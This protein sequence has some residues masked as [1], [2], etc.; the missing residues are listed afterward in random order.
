MNASFSIE[1]PV[2]LHFLDRELLTFFG[3]YKDYPSRVLRR[4]LWDILFL[5]YEPLY[6]S[7][8]LIFESDP[9]WDIITSAPI[10]FETGH[11]ELLQKGNSLKSEIGDKQEQYSPRD[12]RSKYQRYFDDSFQIVADLGPT[13]RHRVTD[14]STIL[15]KWLYN[16]LNAEG[17]ARSAARLRLTA[18]SAELFDCAPRVLDAIGERGPLAITRYL[19]RRPYEEHQISP[20][21]RSAFDI[22]ITE[23]YVISQLKERDGTLATGLSNGFA[24][25]DHFSETYPFHH[26]PLWDRIYKLLG[27]KPYVRVAEATEIVAVREA[28]AFHRFVDT[29]RWFIVIAWDQWHCFPR[30]SEHSPHLF[31]GWAASQLHRLVGSIKDV[32]NNA[33]S[34]LKACEKITD[35]L[36]SEKEVFRMA[37]MPSVH[38]L[39]DSD[40]STIFVVHGRNK[41]AR[42]A[43]FSFL[44]ALQ[45]R[46]LEWEHVVRLTGKGAPY[47]GEVLE[48]GFNAARAVIVLFTGDDSAHLRPEVLAAGEPSEAPT[49]QPRPNVILEAGM[50]L[51]MAPDRT[52]IVE[53]S[54]SELR[55]I[56]DLVGRHVIRM[57]NSSERR[58]VLATRLIS[59]GCKVDQ[60][61]GD[62]FSAGDFDGAAV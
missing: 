5:T 58:N 57:N 37:K 53:I 46:P 18:Q 35:A 39:G 41:K 8:S 30:D 3:L 43:M 13:I 48:A 16:E 14:T 31:V 36:P 6:F 17:A 26:I 22:K 11:I 55:G 28:P 45:L 1:R 9:A 40:P 38:P 2:Y 33:E 56:S 59:V 32:A 24:Y 61:G 19:F 27:L 4:D 60:A 23:G 50:A 42:E 15:E 25:F 47:V 54:K 21:V 49:P 20:R 52:I 10:L 51:G 12:Q 62:W 44:R 7:T 29:V 34:F